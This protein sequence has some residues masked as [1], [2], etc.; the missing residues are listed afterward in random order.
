MEHPYPSYAARSTGLDVCR[1]LAILLVVT[2][3]LLEH[4]QPNPLI[5]QAGF[6]GQFGVDLFYC[7][8]GFLI[9]RIL[10]AESQSWHEEPTAGLL[11]FWFRR[12]MR[13]LPLY[14]FY[15]A[16]LL[17]LNW[18]RV[19]SLGAQ[20]PYL[21]FSQNLAS[22]MPSYYGPSVWPMPIFYGLSW[23]LAVEEWFYL[24]FPL[25]LLV[26]LGFGASARKA[27]LLAVAVFCIVPFGL[28]W[29]LPPHIPELGSFDEGLRHVVIFRL[30][31]LGMGVLIAYLFTYERAHFDALRRLWPLA[32]VL[33]V[34][35]VTVTKL[36]YP[37]FAGSAALAPV[38]YGMSAFAF[39]LL[40]P[41][42][43]ALPMFRF[44]ILNR[45]FRFTSLISYSLYLGHILSFIAVMWFL[46]RLHLYEQVYPNPWILYPLFFLAA[47]GLAT[48]TYLAI[49]RPMLRWRDKA[50]QGAFHPVAV[51]QTASVGKALVS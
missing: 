19:N 47:F 22:S 45:F 16:V 40:I 37:G 28:R 23:S 29:Y 46:Q 1:S 11:G 35:L 50:T 10:L 42:F 5:R 7:L 24:L 30:D 6:L 43:H 25:L 41:K 12:W 49:E 2:G 51:D 36:G 3:H 27:A 44:E 48:L 4:S 9:G 39:A 31:A 21:F 20:V 17:K 8:S 13:T 18:T 33:V 15:L 32:A 14:Y 26:F 38:Y 34:L